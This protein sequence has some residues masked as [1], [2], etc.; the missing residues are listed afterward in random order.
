MQTEN[1]LILGIEKQNVHACKIVIKWRYT[2]PKCVLQRSY[3][4]A[5]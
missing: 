2:L 4:F 5:N 3:I 1:N